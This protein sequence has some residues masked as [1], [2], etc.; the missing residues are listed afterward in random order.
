MR[1]DEVRHQK[2]KHGQVHLGELRCELGHRQRCGESV[3]LGVA[4]QHRIQSMVW[5]SIISHKDVLAI[6]DRLGKVPWRY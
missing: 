3:H 4:F 6:V 5:A 1:M 2:T